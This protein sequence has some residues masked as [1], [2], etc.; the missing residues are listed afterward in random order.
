ETHAN[1]FL[2]NNTYRAS[3]KM[4]LGLLVSRAGNNGTDTRAALAK[5]YATN[6]IYQFTSGTSPSFTY[7][8]NNGITSI[9]ENGNFL[10]E[11]TSPVTRVFAGG[12]LGD[13]LFSFDAYA[14]LEMSGTDGDTTVD[15]SYSETEASSTTSEKENQV[16]SGVTSANRIAL[17]GRVSKAFAEK[18]VLTSGALEVGLYTGSIESNR[19]VSYN[20]VRTNTNALI[21]DRTTQNITENFKWLDG[22]VSGM[23][24]A[25]SITT[26][27]QIDPKLTLGIGCGYN[28]LTTT[29]AY[30]ATH[31]YSSSRTFNDGDAYTNDAD[32]YR[33][34]TNDGFINR[35][36]E[37]IQT[38]GRVTLPVGFVWDVNSKW[39]VRASAS[40][41]I[42]VNRVTNSALENGANTSTTTT[43]YGDGRIE[44]TNGTATPQTLVSSLTGN[45]SNTVVSQ[46]LFA[47]GVGF[48]PLPNFTID[49]NTVF[50]NFAGE[51]PEELCMLDLEWYRSLYLSA[52]FFFGAAPKAAT[53]N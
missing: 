52:T 21:T 46:T 34:T 30:L 9:G 12:R 18:R 48:K 50:R 10:L 38:Y 40:H 4:T 11:R 39:Q 8:Y 6:G 19:D 31:S 14:G 32:D 47:Y 37:R 29:T 22:D 45:P 16:A 51:D 13:D 23:T 28:W 53:E 15:Y 36:A 27:F 49:L 7:S 44:K 42:D 2:V 41:Q 35:K 33:E 5:L 24:A 20:L 1:S 3:D 17:G 43:V 26:K 25:L